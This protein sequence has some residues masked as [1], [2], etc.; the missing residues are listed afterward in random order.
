M[1]NRSKVSWSWRP[2]GSVV[3]SMGEGYD[4]RLGQTVRMRIVLVVPGGVDPQGSEHV[5]P[6]VH[7]LVA[8]LSSVHDV[9]VIAVGHGPEPGTW[10]LF[11]A[12][13]VNV[14]VGRHSKV[15]IARVVR[16]VSRLAGQGTRPDVIHGLWANLPGFAA[17]VAARRHR[18]PSVVSVC[19]GEFV[20][21]PDIGYGGGLRRGTLLMA[22][23][24]TRSATA[25]TAATSWMA[26]H[27]GDRGGKVDE[28]IPLGADTSIFHS[29]GAPAAA[30]RLVHVGNINRVKDQTLL[31]HAFSQVLDSCAGA[32]LDIAGLDTLGGEIQNLAAKLGIESRIH[33]HGYLPPPQLASM[34]HGAALHV[35]SSRHDA[36]PVALLEAAACGVPTIGTAVGHVDDFA[37][38]PQPAA[39]AVGGRQPALL[40]G[41][42][43]ALLS[44]VPRRIDVAARAHDWAVA[45]D[46]RH[47]SRSFESL[48]H[49]LIANR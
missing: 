41:G 6:F 38:L 11:G 42:I 3:V 34:L 45:H 33:F 27:V 37:A 47:T 31:L 10:P 40:A 8:D 44:D 25:V 13:V 46:S 29:V 36:G 15:D 43:T 48:Y 17:S 19:G 24:A 5:I 22:R 20:S 1:T 26:S 7:G 9:L 30:N 49:R 28:I 39:V 21:L 18:C 14:P 2:R 32:T 35:L 23:A 12:T 16:I 4:S